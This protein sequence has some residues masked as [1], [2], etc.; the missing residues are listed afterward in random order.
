MCLSLPE[1]VPTASEY[2]LQQHD[3]IFQDFCPFKSLQNY[4]SEREVGCVVRDAF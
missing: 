3:L 1:N 4:V 2:P